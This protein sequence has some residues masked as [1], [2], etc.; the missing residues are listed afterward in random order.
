MLPCTL[1]M[2]RILS[3]R[4]QRLTKKPSADQQVFIW[5][6]CR[7]R[8]FLF[9]FFDIHIFQKALPMLPNL[10]SDELCSLNPG[11]TIRVLFFGGQ[12]VF[13]LLQVLIVW[14]TL[15]SAK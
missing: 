1:R 10:L 13:I 8:L 15:L 14:L 6:R 5:S 7:T 11:F 12:L 3:K 2:C 4:I 9:I